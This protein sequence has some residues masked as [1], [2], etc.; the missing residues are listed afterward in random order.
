MAVR[1]YLLHKSETRKIVQHNNI[2]QFK[3]LSVLSNCLIR[4]NEFDIAIKSFTRIQCI[5]Q[6]CIG[7]RLQWI[8][9][10]QNVYFVLKLMMFL[11][12]SWW[13]HFTIVHLT[14]HEACYSPKANRTE[15]IVTNSG[16]TKSQLNMHHFNRL[17][18]Q[19]RY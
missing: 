7:N 14:P 9:D 12:W 2:K 4:T 16:S 5:G 13:S 6:I 1:K 8:F 19:I 18:K 17:C 15:I 10:E 3:Y 11:T